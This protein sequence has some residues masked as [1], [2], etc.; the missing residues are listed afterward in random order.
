MK[1]L[2]VLCAIAFLGTACSKDYP[3]DLPIEEEKI[4]TEVEIPEN[5]PYSLI[6][7]VAEADIFQMVTFKLSDSVSNDE[8]NFF[9]FLKY[10]V[11]DSLIW[12]VE[13]A[14]NKVHLIERDERGFGVQTEWGHHFYA[15]GEYKTYLKGYREGNLV[16]NDSIL[17]HVNTP[18]DKDFL[19]FSWNEIEEPLGANNGYVNNGTEEYYFSIRPGVREQIKSI[20]VSMI[21]EKYFGEAY[22]L[23][24]SNLPEQAKSVLVNYITSMY[25]TEEYSLERDDVAS[26]YKQLFRTHLGDKDVIK[27]WSTSTTNV[28]LVK[29]SIEYGLPARYSILAEPSYK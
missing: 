3:I 21:Y 12:N 27:I 14:T 17:V 9:S 13:G 11:L 4:E 25:G 10:K 18:K 19:H 6:V 23:A 15:S 28:A 7:D 1:I 26:I 29:G 22:K 8:E 5:L 20:S 2:Y 24:P 16:V